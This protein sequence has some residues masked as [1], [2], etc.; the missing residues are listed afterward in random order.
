MTG[1]H[2]SLPETGI[3]IV[4]VI[5]GILVVGVFCAG[6]SLFDDLVDG[7]IACATINRL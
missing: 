3:E 7:D 5:S 2:R 1:V 4:T 6:G